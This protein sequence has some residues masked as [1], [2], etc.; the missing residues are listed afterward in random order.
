MTSTKFDANVRV[1]AVVNQA[2]GV[3][4]GRVVHLEAPAGGFTSNPATLFVDGDRG[5][6]GPDG[7]T[8]KTIAENGDLLFVG[9][10]TAELVGFG[11]TLEAGSQGDI[12]EVMLMGFA[13]VVLSKAN[14][15]VAVGAA[16]E[17]IGAAGEVSARGAG[18]VTVAY[19]TQAITAAA[20]NVDDVGDRTIR[21]FVVSG[22]AVN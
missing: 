21:A 5:Q 8:A 3:L 12:I 13:D 14:T 9:Y 18:H 6:S 1:R 2:G 22:P 10:G 17:T 4:K 19:A 20:R 15:A 7:I 11:V 16:L